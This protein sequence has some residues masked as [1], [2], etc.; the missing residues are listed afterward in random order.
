MESKNQTLPKPEYGYEFALRLAQEQLAAIG[1][2]EQQCRRSDSRYL[3]G[4]VSVEFLHRQ[5]I[6]TLPGAEIA[7][8]DGG[9]D[10][11]IRDKLL[12]LHYFITAKGTPL[13]SRM[14]NYKEL[15]EGTAYFP[16]FYKRA[17]KPLTDNFGS[18]PQRLA[19]IAGGLGASHADYGDTAVTINAFRRVPITLVL[20]SGDAEFP[21]EGNV[22]FDSTITDY[23]PIEDIN[24]LCETIAWKLVRQ[25]KTGGDNP[26]TK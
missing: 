12:I 23:L 10:M 5:Y 17:I 2:I 4:A 20:W 19:E 13:P 25:L 14:I 6:I 16:T 21:A 3:D 9:E 26:V 8:Q 7:P 22:L 18:Q 11:P 24:V 15:P 1:D